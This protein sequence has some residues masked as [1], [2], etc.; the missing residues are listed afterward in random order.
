MAGGTAYGEVRLIRALIDTNVI[1]DVL[2]ARQP[3]LED[4]ARVWQVHEAD[5]FSGVIAA[6]TLTNI[7]YVVRRNAGLE[8]AHDAVRVC[9]TTFEIIPVDRRALANAAVLPGNDFEDNVL[10]ACASLA[11]LDAI[12]TRDLHDFRDAPILVLTPTELLARIRSA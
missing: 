12:V 4:S 10:I 3:W 8:R 2:L 1:L 5:R 11:N 6:T 9:L 7:F